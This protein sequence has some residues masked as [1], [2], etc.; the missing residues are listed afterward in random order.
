MA[1]RTDHD[2]WHEQHLL[3]GEKLQHLLIIARNGPMARNLANWWPTRERG[4]GFRRIHDVPLR[5]RQFKF[6]AYT[7]TMSFFVLSTMAM[8]SL[9]SCACTLAEPVAS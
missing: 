5:T 8:S 4:A 6:P 1:L 3:D 7:T 2:L 9:C